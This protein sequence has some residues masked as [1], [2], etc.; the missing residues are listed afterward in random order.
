MRAPEQLGW[1]R[2]L[3][4]NSTVRGSLFTLLH[5]PFMAA[6]ASLVVIGIL[7]LSSFDPLTLV[8]SIGAVSLV[9][10]GEHMLDDT[11]LVGKPWGT[12]FTDRTLTIFA[13][14][15][16]LAALLISV[17][18]SLYLGSAIPLIG[19]GLGIV[20]SVL[21]GLEIWFFH[22]VAFGAV[23]MG[24]IL[25]FSFLAQSVAV[26]SPSSLPIMAL[27]F[28]GGAIYGFVLLNTYERTKVDKA[29]WNPLGII[30]LLGYFAALM[31]I[32]SFL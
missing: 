22:A 2:A 30:F 24:A 20:V 17:L 4:H 29:A 32:I 27:L 9:L 28:A 18:A 3:V 31:A 16:F 23:G 14:A 1:Y 7:P 5:V 8:L 6:F 25:T 26:K 10:Y 13:A 15:S 19:V 12:V 11:T 21:Y